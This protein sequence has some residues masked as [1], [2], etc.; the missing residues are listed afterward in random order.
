M[1]YLLLV[2]MLTVNSPDII[3]ENET[4]IKPHPGGQTEFLT[5]DAFETLFGGAAGPGKTFGLVLDALGLQFR[6]TPL[7]KPAIEVP[8]YR[9]VLFRRQTT[10]LAKLIDECKTYYPDFGGMYLSAR[11]GDPGASFNFP[12]YYSKNGKIYKTYTEGA[13]IY[14]CHLN[15][16][17]DKENHQGLEYQ[18]VGFDELTQFLFSQYIYLFSR[19]RSTIHGLFPRVRATTNPTGIGLNWVKKRFKPQIEQNIVKY[20]ITNPTDEKD[21]RG[22]EVEKGTEDALSRVYIPGKLKENLTLLETDP[23]YKARIKAMGPKMAKALLESDWDAMEGQFFDSWNADVHVIKSKYYLPYYQLRQQEVLGVID[24]GRVMVFSLLAKDCNGNVVLFDQMTSIAQVRQIR[25]KRLMKFL[26]ERG[27]RDIQIVGDTDMWQKDAFDL[28][29]QE[30]PARAFIDAKDDDD[31]E[32]TGLKLV[33]VSKKSGDKDKTYRIHCNDAIK[34]A[35]YY[36]FNDRGILIKQP[37]FKVYERCEEFRETFPALPT[38]EDNPEDIA[39]VDF[40]HWFD[41]MKMGFMV[42]TEATE[43]VVDTRPGWAREL[44]AEKN[45]PSI[46]EA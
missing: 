1:Y 10:Q 7:G 41:S 44:N 2:I 20:F 13:K 12:K 36:E 26:K 27:M 45:K 11:K 40:D 17:K 22:I 16:E 4:I 46:M 5:C 43:Q 15:E 9:G 21:Y 35:L 42:I 24:Y 23:G 32:F 30:E 6:E 14:L 37:K 28:A 34:N 8:Q 19:C 38:D 18:Y 39:D 3:Q 29:D 33:K 31:P 25:V